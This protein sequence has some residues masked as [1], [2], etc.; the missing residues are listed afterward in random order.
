VKKSFLVLILV[1]VFA[2]IWAD[3][4]SAI[5]AWARKNKAD[6]SMCHWRLNRLNDFGKDFQRQGHRVVGDEGSKPSDPISIS[7][8]TSITTKFRAVFNAGDRKLKT[9][10]HVASSSKS[11]TWDFQTE[12]FSVYSGGPLDKNFSYYLE[13]YFYENATYQYGRSKF[14]DGFVQYNQSLGEDNQY[15]WVR[16]GQFSNF[17]IANYG[18]AA[19]MGITRPTVLDTAL[20][21]GAKIRDRD[22]GLELGY[23]MNDIILTGAFINGNGYGWAGDNNPEKDYYVTVQKKLGS[24]A[25]GTDVGLYYY[26]GMNYTG[27]DND[28]YRWGLLGGADLPYGLGAHLSGA[29]MLANNK[30]AATTDSNGYFVQYDQLLTDTWEASLRYDFIDTNTATASNET[31]GLTAI[32]SYSLSQWA[33]LTTEARMLTESGA[34]N[35]SVTAELQFMY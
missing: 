24:G 35:N 34:A 32:G 6:C 5:S 9:E 7:D 27:S 16:A 17:M 22:L 31:S 8:Y 11:T 15:Y 13:H 29:Y 26:K 28:Y 25:I 3:E 19:R 23:N 14:A 2:A 12:A 20:G 33:R 1:F 18:G 21:S 10:E 30:A 4:S